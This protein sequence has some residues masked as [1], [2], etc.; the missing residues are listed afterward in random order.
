MAF[1]VAVSKTNASRITLSAAGEVGRFAFNNR[2]TL[3]IT[4]PRVSSSKCLGLNQQ[5]S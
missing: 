1:D 2:I 5:F 4:R 3:S